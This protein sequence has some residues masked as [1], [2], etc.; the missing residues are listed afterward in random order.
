MTYFSIHNHTSF[1]NIRLLDSINSPLSLIDHA[2]KIGLSGVVITDHEALCS[3]IKVNQ[4]AKKMRDAHPD[5]TIALGNEIYLTDTR[6][7]NQQYYHF[8]LIAKN[9]DGHK[10]LKELS[11][12]AWYNMYEDRGMERVP[13][14]KSELREIMKKYPGSLIATTACLGGELSTN[15]LT[16]AQNESG[17]DLSLAETAYCNIKNFLSFCLDLFGEDFYIECAPAL[18]SEQII[19]NRKLRSIA[20]YYKIKMV[21]GTD[22][23][24]L[25][26]QDRSVHKAYL[27]SKDGEREVD[28]F[29]EF[30]YMMEPEEAHKY[31]MASFE[32]EAF[33][34]QLFD[35]TLDL[36][37]KIEFYSLERHQSIPEV[38]VKDYPKTLSYFGVNNDL[39]DDL[40]TTWPTLYKLLLSDNIQERYWVNQCLET[41]IYKGLFHDERYLD[42]LEEEARVKGIIGEKLQTCMYAYPNT[43]QHY[44][45]LFWECGSTVGAGRGSACSALNHYL[46]GITQ[47]DPIEWNLPFWRYLNEARTE[48]GDVDIDLAPSKLQ[49]IFEEIRKERGELGLVQ[50]STFGTETSKSAILTA[51]RGY[52]SDEYPNGIDVDIGQYLSSLVPIER[53]FVWSIGELVFGNPEK[54]RQPQ[55]LFINEV[56]KYPGLLEI[57]LGIEGLVCQRGSHASGVILFDDTI[58]D[59]AAIMRTPSGAIV[60][61]WDLHDQEA[62]GGVKYDFLLTDVQDIIIQ[63]ISFLQDFGEIEKDLTLKEVYDKYLH[64][65]VLPKDDEKMWDALA[66]NQVVN[67][68]QFDSAVG[69]QAAKKI[70]PHNPLEMSDA[71]SL[72]RLMPS[73]PGAETPLDKYVRFKNN[74]KLWYQEMTNAGLTPDEQKTLE[75]YF[76]QSYGVPP[77]QEQMMMMLMDDKICS[78]DLAEANAA[79]KIVGK[80]QMDK[81]P[82]LHEKVLARAKSSALGNYV[83]SCGIGPQM[84]YSFSVIHALAYSYVGMQTLYLAT[85]FN[86][87]YWNTACLVVNSGSLDP[88]KE[89]STNYTK[90]AKAIGTIRS[91]NINIALPDINSSMFGFL[92]DVQNNRIIFGLKGILNVGDELVETIIQNRPYESPADFIQKVNPN[93]QAMIALIKAG[94]FDNMGD[95]KTILGWYIWEMCDKKSCLN[96]RNLQGLMKSGMTPREGDFGTAH[97]I[98]EF[99]RYLK[100]VCQKKDRYLL[101]DRAINFLEDIGQSELIDVIDEKFILAI[102]PWEKFYQKKMDIFRTWIKDN[103]DKLLQEFNAKIFQEDWNKYAKGT[104]S[105][106]EMEVLC[107]YYHEHE[108]AH[109][110]RS[111]YGIANFFDMPEDPLVEKSFETKSGAKVNLYKIYRICGTCIAKEKPKNTVSLLTAEGVVNIK[112]S[113]EYFSMFDKQ[114]SEKQADGK[115]KIME[116]S[117]FNRGSMVMVQGFRRGNT[118]VPK[119]YASTGGHQLYKI[120][121]IDNVGDLTLRTERYQGEVEDDEN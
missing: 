72:M 82:E 120:E 22:S 84:G 55:T 51:C 11:S 103:H 109:V 85:R 3:H 48:L 24:Y 34:N 117:W 102:K 36:Q 90:L 10:A 4:Y 75:P 23:H 111:K 69:S 64:P 116:R 35:N 47:L 21:F 41:L 94:C 26:P 104:I 78:F 46:L 106:W 67:C 33:V 110:N 49:K 13:T 105:A 18:S 53:G 16:M 60:T 43:L 19:V 38:P 61:Q 101:D 12:T 74:I 52:R 107:F 5:F 89:D 39:R 15:A 98:F 63:T 32:D 45:N 20:N 80:K 17:K 50:V 7:R 97:R 108:L 8:I 70:R 25:T 91:A 95:R 31:L 59:T 57:M 115:K 121:S 62:A 76:L 92:P 87:I 73:E 118:F 114:I 58:F 40:T 29:Y 1:S 113:K 27:N 30:S 68:F 56:K 88:D 119:K 99:N 9:E 83:W 93:K 81:I 44:I 37:K 14:L 6:D 65:S 100:A 77:S 42:R 54:G 96:L 71:N 66:N 79:R 112:F 28:A 86:P 2:I